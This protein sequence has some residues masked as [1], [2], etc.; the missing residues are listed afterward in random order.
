MTGHRPDR[1]R[2]SNTRMPRDMAESAF[3]RILRHALRRLPGARAAALVDVEGE[4]VD[5]AGDADPFELKIAAAHVRILIG[6]IEAQP[7]LGVPR[8]LA[9]RGRHA[10]FFADVLP[11]DYVLVLTMHRRASVAPSA[12][13][14]AACAWALHREAGF[15]QRPTRPPWFAADVEHDAKRRPTMVRTASGAE[16]VEVLG[17]LTALRRLERGFRVRLERGIEATL[18]REPGGYWY[19]DEPIERQ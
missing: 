10:G 1:E 6:T 9:V 19:I 17:A 16:R 18:V 5:Y 7:K 4:T 3:A 14:L 8:S 12:R 13:A 2:P 11:D 15:T